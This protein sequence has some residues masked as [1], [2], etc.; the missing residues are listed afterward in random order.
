LVSKVRKL[1]ER[2]ADGAAADLAAAESQKQF[3]L[4]SQVD[5]QIENLLREDGKEV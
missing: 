4:E 2:W 1:E 3:M 5:L